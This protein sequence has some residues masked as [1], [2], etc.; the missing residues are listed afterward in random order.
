MSVVYRVAVAVPPGT[1]AGTYA[2][3]GVVY[4]ADT[5]PSESSATSKRIELVVAT[6]RPA[7][8]APRWPYLVAV[9][10]VVL[11][12]GVVA[13][14][15]LTRGDADAGPP[16]PDLRV[17]TTP[18]CN[19]TPLFAGDYLLGIDAG[20]ASSGAAVS[21]AS[22]P[23]LLR[24]ERTGA[25]SLG[26]VA[27]NPAPGAPSTT[28]T[29]G[30]AA[31]DTGIVDRYTLVVDPDGLVNESDEANNAVTVEVSV[32]GAGTVPCSVV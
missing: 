13:A 30:V 19:V 18:T 11:V 17:V 1:A 10:A 31:A 16:L 2:A 23:V 24:G 20:V 7:A 14:I 9:L 22:V 25:E 3:T 8:G 29:V 15:V 26:D 12:V 4:S 28:L 6:A 27:I 21:R 5:D 32:V